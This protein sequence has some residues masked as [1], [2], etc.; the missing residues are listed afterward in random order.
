[1]KTHARW[2]RSSAIAAGLA[3]SN[4][5]GA[6]GADTANRAEHTTSSRQAARIQRIEQGIEPV[7]FEENQPPL[8]LDVAQLMKLNND[9]GLSVAVIDG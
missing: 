5:A 7:R 4:I 9:P 8:Q 3:I 1:M 2:M 6:V